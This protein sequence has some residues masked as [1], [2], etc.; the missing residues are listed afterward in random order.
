[1]HDLI[2]RIRPHCTELSVHPRHSPPRLIPF[3]VLTSSLTLSLPI[4]LGSGSWLCVLPSFLALSYHFSQIFPWPCCPTQLAAPPLRSSG[5]LLSPP[6]SELQLSPHVLPSFW[7]LG[8]TYTP[9]AWPHASLEDLCFCN[10]IWNSN[11]LLFRGYGY[12]II[13]IKQNP[14]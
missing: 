10:G 7:Y 9:V 8:F 3:V 12:R 2:S 4:S 11:I 1:M 13:T 5:L 14:H 6:S